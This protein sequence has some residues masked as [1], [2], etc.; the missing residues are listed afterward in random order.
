[1]HQSGSESPPDPAEPLRREA[2][3]LELALRALLDVPSDDDALRR[4]RDA[5]RALDPDEL[6]DCAQQLDPSSDALVALLA[7]EN[8]TA[9]PHYHL[10]AALAAEEVA[11]RGYQPGRSRDVEAAAARWQWAAGKL[12]DALLL[13]GLPR[14]LL[15]DR[16]R[17]LRWEG[18]DE[19]AKHL[20]TE[21]KGLVYLRDPRSA[22][23][24]Y[25]LT[26]RLWLGVY[27][28]VFKAA[29]FAAQHFPWVV[30]WAHLLPAA[31]GAGVLVAGYGWLGLRLGGG[32]AASVGMLTGALAIAASVVAMLL[33]APVVL[34]RQRS[35]SEGAEG[36]SARSAAGPAHR[37]CAAPQETTGSYSSPRRQGGSSALVPKLMLD[38]L[39]PR[40]AGLSAVGIAGLA[41]VPE[42]WQGIWDQA[43]AWP[44]WQGIRGLVTTGAF[45]L[46]LLAFVAAVL[47]FGIV[48][49]EL[50]RGSS[51]FRELLWGAC[52][53]SLVALFQALTI[54]TLS[55]A[56]MAWLA[57]WVV[58]KMLKDV[59]LG[60]VDA[61]LDNKLWACALIFGTWGWL[62]GMLL[63]HL[64][65]PGAIAHPLP[66]E[67]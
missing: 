58:E 47:G 49:M 56:L 22:R 15:E 3:K 34:R 52:Q 23:I 16:E 4:R 40:P 59:A 37:T 55:V 31:L 6:A 32:A 35:A 43:S 64:W 60:P 28:Q 13:P 12:A 20:R 17:R 5:I 62:L 51:L 27:G 24:V 11:W 66:E 53:V 21:V 65:Q 42:V 61:L 19:L 26:V 18:A 44:H 67:A 8:L 41:L 14:R 39:L 48:F 1:M 57:P 54:A 25:L 38:L 33:I 45:R 30:S 36:Q 50:A 46:C 9:Y 7:T 63:Q 29:A 10:C 2:E